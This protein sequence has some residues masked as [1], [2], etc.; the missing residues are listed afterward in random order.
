[1]T[2]PSPQLCRELLERVAVVERLRA[3]RNEYRALEQWTLAGTIPPAIRQEHWRIARL[4]H[5]L[6][7][8]PLTLTRDAAAYAR[9]QLGMPIDAPST[10]R[11]PRQ[12]GV[13]AWERALAEA[14]AA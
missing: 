1:M 10:V 13:P 2:P 6:G 7:L 12:R 14:P 5:E 9:A 3:I 4:A 8:P 11:P